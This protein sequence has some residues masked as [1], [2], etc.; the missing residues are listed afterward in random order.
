MAKFKIESKGRKYFKCK[1]ND[2]Y[3]C[4]LLINDVSENCEIDKTYVFDTKDLSVRSNNGTKLIFEPLSLVGEKTANDLEKEAVI[5]DA[6]KWLNYAFKDTD[7]GYDHSNAIE[8]ALRV[9]ATIPELTDEVAALKEKIKQNKYGYE[10]KY[11]KH[12]LDTA[13]KDVVDGKSQSYAIDRVFDLTKKYPEYAQ[14][15]E[16]LQKAVMA[17]RTDNVAMGGSTHPRLLY[18]ISDTPPLNKVIKSGSKYIVFTGYGKKFKISEDDPSI[19]GSR[20]LGHEGDYGCYCYYR[21]A[22]DDE[23]EK[24]V[25]KT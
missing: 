12:I 17:N 15:L 6:R 23:I 8:T 24:Y 13:E 2:K 21:Y 3:P 19:H 7:Q 5:K 25:N 1:L 9:G 22:T 4:M 14:R 11:A 16:T 18:P 20:L 10:L